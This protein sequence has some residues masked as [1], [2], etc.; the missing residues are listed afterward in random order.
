MIRFYAENG[1]IVAEAED[2][3]EFLD[4]HDA[5]RIL[6]MQADRIALLEDRLGDYHGQQS[7]EF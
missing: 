6:N 7:V 3:K 4:A 1:E 2:F 5:A